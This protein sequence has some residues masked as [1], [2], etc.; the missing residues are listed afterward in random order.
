MTT[1]IQRSAGHDGVGRQRAAGGVTRLSTLKLRRRYVSSP[2]PGARL[3]TVG[4]S[5]VLVVHSRDFTKDRW[6]RLA[7]RAGLVGR[8]AARPS[9]ARVRRWQAAEGILKNQRMAGRKVA[10]IVH[11]APARPDWSRFVTGCG[12]MLAAHQHP[13]GPVDGALVSAERS[14]S[15]SAS[16]LGRRA[17]RADDD[18]SRPAVARRG[19]QSIARGQ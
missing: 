8:P 3:R 5:R 4:A 18:G 16:A 15:R 17:P 1:A 11:A 13:S 14:A 2:S 10:P 6:R 12:P 19:H 9:A 7:G